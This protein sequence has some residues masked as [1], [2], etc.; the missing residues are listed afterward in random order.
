L[1]STL[2]YPSSRKTDVRF[3]GVPSGS[4]VKLDFKFDVESLSIYKR[5]STVFNSASQTP[6][7]KLLVVYFVTGKVC[8]VKG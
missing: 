6:P 8:T 2:K 3:S 5:F 4:P 1:F 7:R